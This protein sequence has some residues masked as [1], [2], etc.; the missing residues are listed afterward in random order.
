MNIRDNVSIGLGV[1]GGAAVA[2][3]AWFLN[4]ALFGVVT[5]VVLG[6]GLSLFI[7][8]RTQKRIWKRELGLKNIDTIYG[9]LYREITANLAKGSP[10]VKSPF[11]MLS[12]SKWQRIKSDYLYH[13]VPDPL[14]DQLER[15][16]ALVDKYNGLLGRVLT[17]VNQTILDEA[18]KFYE[19]P[20]AQIEYATF[21]TPGSNQNI[22]ID[23]CVIFGVH[24][25]DY[26]RSIYSEMGTLK[27]SVA[28]NRQRT[29]ERD[30]S[31][32]ESL[33]TFDKFFDSVC[34][35]VS[36]LDVVMEI[37]KTLGGLNFEGQEV[38]ERTLRQ[39]R[40]P[41]SM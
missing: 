39:I 24:P 13:F 40:E 22:P 26:L 15:H 17:R 11:E 41:W 9:P 27:F 20:I 14:K 6:T 33:K 31:G 21:W 7:Q 16:Y 38:Q 12:R 23:T 1:A 37:K 29:G 36:E 5:G 18:S 3:L 34:K 19:M 25:R 32:S 4:S 8:S 10:S 28:L 35:T 30:L 2:G